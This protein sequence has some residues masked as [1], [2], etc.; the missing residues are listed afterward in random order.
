MLKKARLNL[1]QT[2]TIV[3]FAIGLAL[4]ILSAF[5]GSSFLVICGVTLIFWSL[6]LFYIKPTKH[7]PI[8]MLNA[9]ANTSS[10]NL[11]RI[12]VE[13]N[14]NEKGYYMP[15]ESLS[16]LQSSTVFLPKGK[17]QIPKAEEINDKLI[18][19]RKNGIYV[20]PPG[21]A[22]TQM[23]EKETGIPFAKT[24]MKYVERTFP[25]LMVETMQLAQEAE[26]KI[27][28]SKVIVNLKGSML[29]DICRE[30]KKLPKTHE[31]IGCLQSSAIACIISKASGKAVV[32][33]SESQNFE[34]KTTKIEL[35]MMGLN[36]PEIKLKIFDTQQTP[37]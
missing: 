21:L 35:E 14:L 25:K 29:N 3:M 28:G 5:Y 18:T 24:H 32:V 27:E 15:P 30:T 7:V 16:D 13:L 11:E 23:M 37:F 8:T 17:T 26:L 10:S 36:Q 4:V 1:V 22:L 2:A 34:D 12:L 31:L 9:L 33:K 19:N 6:I 20:T